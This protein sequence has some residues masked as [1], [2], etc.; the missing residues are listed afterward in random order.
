[1]TVPL[2]LLIVHWIADFRLQSDQMALKK[3]KENKWLTIHCLTYSTAFAL[4]FVFFW[5][6]RIAFEF[7]CLTF[8]FHWVTDYFTSRT[9]TRLWFFKP[10]DVH[11]NVGTKRYELYAQIGGNRHEFFCMIGLDQLIHAI[12]LA[13]TYKWL[14]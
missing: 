11:Y 10:I 1:M 12:T 5:G 3:S 7:A 13:L 9:T 6:P 2:S 8:I 14:L 4:A